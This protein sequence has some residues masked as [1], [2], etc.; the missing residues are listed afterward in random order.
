MG[1]R[2]LPWLALMGAVC[3][4]AGV[5][6]WWGLAPDRDPGSGPSPAA[7]TDDRSGV[8]PDVLAPELLGSGS[9][10]RKAPESTRFQLRVVN[11]RGNALSYAWVRI[12]AHAAPGAASPPAP[13]RVQ[14]DETGL[15]K[16]DVEAA[17]IAWVKVEVE[18]RDEPVVARAWKQGARPAEAAA[19]LVPVDDV[20]QFLG[21]TQGPDGEIRADQRVLYRLAATSEAP[22][23][24]CKSD[25]SDG[26]GVLVLGP[27]PRG[28]EIE[29]RPDDGERADATNPPAD[30]W[31]RAT[32]NRQPVAILLA[33]RPTFRLKILGVAPDAEVP[34]GTGWRGPKLRRLTDGIW[35][36]DEESMRHGG[37]FVI[38]PLEDGRFAS[39]RDVRAEKE[40]IPVELEPGVA[41]GGH[42]VRQGQSLRLEG[43]VIARGPGWESRTPLEPDGTF[44]FRGTPRGEASVWVE[45][46]DKQASTRWVG[47]AE[48]RGAAPLAIAL[49]PAFVLS[50]RVRMTDVVPE[51]A[52]SSALEISGTWGR[53]SLDL[54]ADGQFRTVVP[55]GMTRVHVVSRAAFGGMWDGEVL[56]LD[57]LR[58]DQE[59]LVLPDERQREDEPE[60]R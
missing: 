29:V 39:L 43:A 41:L 12:G 1:L 32:A 11:S 58:A 10:S 59:G 3:V 53:R 34:I 45:A 19:E 16:V 6:A 40:P 27:F 22:A 42:V 26:R 36:P 2:R 37:H 14:A 21:V 25:R 31:Q 56:L 20:E 50:G 49:V 30:G 46:F 13:L 52:A 60:L 9:A 55:G 54:P 47:I 4:G 28:S 5:L 38:G 57:D 18:G 24:A 8:G 35:T 48:R 51:E 23:G 17:R 44:A 33:P 7:V 15:V